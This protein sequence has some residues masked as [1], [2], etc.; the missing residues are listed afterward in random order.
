MMGI[1]IFLLWIGAAY[2]V[3]WIGMPVMV[4]ILRPLL[5]RFA[6]LDMCGPEGWFIDTRNRSGILDYRFGL[7]GGGGQGVS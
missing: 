7:R 2:A 5:V 1:A 6:P 3:C 4:W